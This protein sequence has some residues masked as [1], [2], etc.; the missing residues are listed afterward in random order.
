MPFTT[1]SD[2][3]NKMKNDLASGAWAYSG[4]TVNGKEMRYATFTQF[5]AAFDYV[6]SEAARERGEVSPRTY[7]AVRNW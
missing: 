7:A 2:L 3:E 6:R 1:W 4:Y 5:K